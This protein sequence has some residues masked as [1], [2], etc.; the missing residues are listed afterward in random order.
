MCSV[1]VLEFQKK[2]P[3]SRDSVSFHTSLSYRQVSAH[4]FRHVK[5]QRNISFQSRFQNWYSSV[6]YRD[7][8][9]RHCP[10]RT[11]RFRREC[12]YDFALASGLHSCRTHVPQ[13]WNL[14]KICKLYNILF[15]TRNATGSWSWAFLT[16]RRVKKDERWFRKGSFHLPNKAYIAQWTFFQVF[17]SSRN[18]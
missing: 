7:L 3:L 18:I 4:F 12:Q 9:L 2:V 17:V 6:T 5:V 8:C 11:L 14:E 1:G 15:C 16:Q 10:H 13:L